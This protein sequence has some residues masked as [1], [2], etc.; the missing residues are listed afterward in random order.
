MNNTKVIE[1]VS[2]EDC[3]KNHKQCAL[4][5]NGK[6]KPVALGANLYPL[7]SGLSHPSCSSVDSCVHAVNPQI[8]KSTPQRL[9][10]N[11]DMC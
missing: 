6:Y 8:T 1:Y 9:T 2:R 10:F 7:V 3:E 11:A 5:N 4:F